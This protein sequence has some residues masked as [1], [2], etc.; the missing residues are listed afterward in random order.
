[1]TG[2]RG[3]WLLKLAAQCVLGGA[4]LIVI[5]FICF[6]FGITLPPAAFAYLTFITLLSLIGS[7]IG[8]LILS[9]AAIACLTYFFTDPVLTSRTEYAE[10]L[11]ALA[12]FLS[13]SLLVTGLVARLQRATQALR[14][15]E[16]LASEHRFRLV[17]EAAPNAIVMID[18]AGKIV[19]VNTQAECVFGYSRNEL[20]GRSIELLVPERFRG[21]HPELRKKFFV[22]PQSRP[23]GAGHDLYG[24][25]KDGGEFPVEIGLSPI[26]AD[27]VAMALST[28]ID[29]T[30][31]KAAQRAL[32]ES[33]AT[34]WH[35][36][37]R[38]H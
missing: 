20:M 7:L 12:A 5:T 8:S 22:N 9:V 11:V 14:D 21:H 16:K 36:S 24:R 23:M 27:G 10:N 25:K 32:R 3:S 34:L 1:M 31:R 38:R 2:D 28:I 15:S 6:R 37:R 19:M 35:A 13:S 30:A 18:N 26:E 17:V 4:G 29:I 33:G